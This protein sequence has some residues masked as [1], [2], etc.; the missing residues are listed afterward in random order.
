MR[1]RDA[2][3]GQANDAKTVPRA[4]MLKVEESS[5]DDESSSSDYDEVADGGRRKKRRR[6]Q[7][8]ESSE[9]EVD[10][11]QEIQESMKSAEAHMS[12]SFKK[13][14]QKNRKIVRNKNE[15]RYEG[16]S[17]DLVNNIMEAGVQH[18]YHGGVDLE[19]K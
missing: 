12:Q 16:F 14:T 15:R 18:L 9:E 7:L 4:Q 17:P 11:D 10:E 13:V 19:K 2:N 8:I 6:S 3:K 5:S 1:G